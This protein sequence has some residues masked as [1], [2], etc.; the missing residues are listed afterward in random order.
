MDAQRPELWALQPPSRRAKP[1]K[2]RDLAAARRGKT[3][4]LAAIATPRLLKIVSSVRVVKSARHLGAHVQGEQGREPPP[5]LLDEPEQLAQRVA[6][7]VIG[8]DVPSA[9]GLVQPV[10]AEDARV[11]E[12][13][14]QPHLLLELRP[15]LGFPRGERATVPGARIGT[16]VRDLPGRHAT[17]PRGRTVSR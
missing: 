11:L 8:D 3:I 7:G 17:R 1:S 16:K 5:T 13:G 14:G 10:D 12:V 6:G 2:W 9:L 15:G 4:A